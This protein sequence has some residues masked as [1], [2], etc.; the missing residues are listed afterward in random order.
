MEVFWVSVIL[1]FLLEKPHFFILE[2]VDLFIISGGSLAVG[3]YTSSSSHLQFFPLP[4]PKG[5]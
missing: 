3:Y 5:N 2:L 4:F 1:D